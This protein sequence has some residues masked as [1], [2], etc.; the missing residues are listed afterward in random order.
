MR[1]SIEYMITHD[2]D[3]FC[4]VDKRFYVH[5]ASNGSLLP[6]FANNREILRYSQ[7]FVSDLPFISEE[8]V[9]YNEAHIQELREYR[10]FDE[11]RYLESFKF[12]AQKGFY[13]FDYEWNEDG[14]G[15][16]RLLVAPGQPISPYFDNMQE[17]LPHITRDELYDEY[18]R[19]TDLLDDIINQI[20]NF[21]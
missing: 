5:L 19:E 8:H 14:Y 7:Q 10:G 1:M 11:S 12:F 4:C 13:S 15:R 2:I 21:G 3:W 9:R 17:F 16:Y 20:I 6:E 18:R